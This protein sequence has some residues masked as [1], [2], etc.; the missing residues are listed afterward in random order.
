MLIKVFKKKIKNLYFSTIVI[1][2]LLVL[3]IVLGIFTL[4]F[5]AQIKLASMHQISSIFLVSSCIYF[6]YLNSK[7]NLQL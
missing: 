2:F 4:I 6:L 1:G 3:Q 5:G 7:P